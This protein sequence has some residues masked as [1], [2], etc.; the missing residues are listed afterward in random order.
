MGWSIKIVMMGTPWASKRHN[1][2]TSPSVESIFAF[3]RYAES[4]HAQVKPEG[5]GA[6]KKTELAKAS[7]LSISRDTQ[8][9]CGLL[10]VMQIIS[11]NWAIFAHSSVM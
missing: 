2:L 8:F 3:P 9:W 10:S 4:G 5:K 11:K 7:E 6:K 1:Q